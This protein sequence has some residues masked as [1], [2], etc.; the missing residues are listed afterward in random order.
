M[1]KLNVFGFFVVSQ[2]EMSLRAIP[3]LRP[4]SSDFHMTATK[5]AQ[6]PSTTMLASV[7]Q[8]HVLDS[9]TVSYGAKTK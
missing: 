2:V 8:E 3:N 7:P 9:L 6:T 1:N 5:I 4:T